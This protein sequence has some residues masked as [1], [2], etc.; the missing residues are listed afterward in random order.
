[1]ETLVEVVKFYFYMAVILIP[2]EYS[3][4]NKKISFLRKEWV[5]DSLFFF[6]QSF[7]WNLVTVTILGYLFSH[8]D[9]GFVLTTRNF[10]G[11]LPIYFQ[12]PIVIFLSDLF[13]YWGHRLQHKYDF[14]WRFHKVHHTAE[15]VDYIA[16]FREHPLDNI[17]TRG[18]ETFPAVFL[19]L[20]LNIIIGFI[21]FRG[22]WA[23]FIH[24]NVELRLGFLEYIFG[25]PHLHHWHHELHKKGLC[26]YANLSPLMD[27]LFGTF[28]SPKQIPEE[29]GINGEFNRSYFSLLIEPIIPNKI[30][31]YLLNKFPFFR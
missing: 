11:K 17:Y 13:I 24:S 23:L 31:I 19:G 8:L 27:L 4:G 30:E 18:I 25:S 12:I 1:M 26:N 28:Y 29:Y 20:D 21:T 5:T 3:F 7:I 9:Y 10:F 14:L 16:A 15:T 6:G 22:L 2:L